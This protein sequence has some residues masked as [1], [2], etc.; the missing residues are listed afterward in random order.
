VAPVITDSNSLIGAPCAG[1][2]INGARLVK[3]VPGLVG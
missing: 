1:S 2:S 3:P